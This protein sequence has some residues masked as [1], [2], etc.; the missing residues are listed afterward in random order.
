VFVLVLVL[1]LVPV[2]LL[3]ALARSATV[4]AVITFITAHSSS[5]VIASAS[6]T[7]PSAVSTIVLLYQY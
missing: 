7:P 2:V 3:L 4:L 5:G 6:A 1:V